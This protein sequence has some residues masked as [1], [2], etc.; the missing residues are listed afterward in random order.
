MT[1]CGSVSERAR[2]DARN[3][4]QSQANGIK[5]KQH[6]DWRLG[7]TIKNMNVDHERHTAS[8]CHQM[9]EE[10]VS[11]LTM[12]IEL[13]SPTSPTFYIKQN[14]FSILL[15]PG[16]ANDEAVPWAQNGQGLPRLKP[17]S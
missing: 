12:S 1:N 8:E 2:C 7:R 17:R 13:R 3:C 5:P 15:F 9:E 4:L 6:A 10:L 16:I 11:M 14:S